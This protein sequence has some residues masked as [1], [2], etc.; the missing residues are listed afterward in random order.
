MA[1][2]E[3]KKILIATDGSENAQKAARSGVKIAA[4]SGAKVIALYV[5]EMET[6]GVTPEAVHRDYVASMKMAVSEHMTKEQWSEFARVADDMWKTER[7]K[8]L[9]EKGSSVTSY[10]EELCKEMGAEAEIRI[11]EGHPAN[12]ILDVAEKENVDL[13]VIGTLGKTADGRFR[14]G[15]VAEKVIRNSPTELLVVR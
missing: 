10:V 15:S 6:V 4:L 9:Q 3:Y 13:L 1:D 8:N 12:V 11:E 14:L 7:H 5:L 2:K